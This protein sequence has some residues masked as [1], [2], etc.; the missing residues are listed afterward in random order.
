M[1]DIYMKLN[2]EYILKNAL[3]SDILVNKNDSNF[4]IKLNNT[5]KDI[6]DFVND[7]KNRDEIVELLIHKYSID[8]ETIKK[9]VDDFI[10]TMLEK[11][12]FI[13]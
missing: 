2:S 13:Y 8:K 4:I 9:D 1:Y 11:N 5:S 10:K 7:G 12:I 3:D 6:I